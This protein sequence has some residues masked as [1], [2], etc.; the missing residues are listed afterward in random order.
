M[1]KLVG[2]WLHYT[3]SPLIHQFNHV[4]PPH[5]PLCH[6]PLPHGKASINGKLQFHVWHLWKV[7]PQ[8]LMDAIIRETE[9]GN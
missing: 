6:L 5:L 8:P 9:G 2:P 7:A 3:R 4:A 1:N